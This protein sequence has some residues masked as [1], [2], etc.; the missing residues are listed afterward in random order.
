VDTT[1]LVAL[2]T[3]IITAISTLGA[4]ALSGYRTEKLERWRAEHA[5]E[6]ERESREYEHGQARVQQARVR[7]EEVRSSVLRLDLSMRQIAQIRVHGPPKQ[8]GNDLAELVRKA[9]P[10]IYEAVIAV[11][12]MRD[13][14]P[15]DRQDRIDELRDAVD[16]V[17]NHVQA[18][19][20]RGADQV[21]R[22]LTSG[23]RALAAVVPV[24]R[25]ATGSGSGDP[26]GATPG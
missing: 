25:S 2:V 4:T 12:R 13:V 26:D 3:G 23:L 19:T 5:L 14:L 1:V 6:R 21:H 20:G 17:F 15:P 7:L 24:E 18:R 22:K 16:Q 8:G 10:H 11:E 9:R